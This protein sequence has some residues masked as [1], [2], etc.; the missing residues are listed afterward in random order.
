MGLGGLHI[1]HLLIILLIVVLIFGT[2][3]LKAMGGDIGGA[4]KGFKK[5]MDTDDDKADAV[6][7]RRLENED[8]DDAE[9]PEQKKKNKSRSA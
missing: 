1:W 7:Q 3:R 8:G 6:E 2:K 9:F 5:A 4:V